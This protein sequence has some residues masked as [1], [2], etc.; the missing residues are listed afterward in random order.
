[1]KKSELL[2]MHLVSYQRY[3]SFLLEQKSMD[4]KKRKFWKEQLQYHASKLIPYGII[5]RTDVEADMA[6][7]NSAMCLNWNNRFYNVNA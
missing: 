4:W 3:A 7:R 2:E 5:K 6:Y 1:M